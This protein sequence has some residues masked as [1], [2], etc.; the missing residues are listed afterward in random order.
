MSPTVT[1]PT[2]TTPAPNLAQIRKAY[3]VTDVEWAGPPEEDQEPCDREF[4]AKCIVDA[5][6]ATDHA[7]EAMMAAERGDLQVAAEHAS[8]A[9]FL[10]LPLGS[11]WTG[12]LG[13]FSDA[14]RAAIGTLTIREAY[15]HVQ[16]ARTGGDRV[17]TVRAANYAREAMAEVER[18]ARTEWGAL[19]E[20]HGMAEAQDLAWR[21]RDA[22]EQGGAESAA[23]YF[24]FCHTIYTVVEGTNL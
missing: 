1:T 16:G 14:I 18:A 20:R 3:Q 24:H 4:W 6:A 2:P 9:W 15:R 7:R 12:P 21:A 11:D 10:A 22:A 8:R 17:A 19:D 5:A 23:P 13:Q